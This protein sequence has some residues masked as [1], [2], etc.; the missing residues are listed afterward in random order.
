M[1]LDK[2]V[3]AVQER[4]TGARNFYLRWLPPSRRW[5]TYEKVLLLGPLLLLVGLS[6][7]ASPA[8]PSD[9]SFLSLPR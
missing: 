5:L 7:P 1:R 3:R 4:L 6:P 9:S 8:G 2:P